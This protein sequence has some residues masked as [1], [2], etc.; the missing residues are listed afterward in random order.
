MPRG[1]GGRHPD[2]A[3]LS[4]QVTVGMVRVRRFT[5]W[6]ANGRSPGRWTLLEESC[7]PSTKARGSVTQTLTRTM[8]SIDLSA[9]GPESAAQ[10]G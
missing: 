9:G 6:T 10:P 8:L 1:G 3:T 5:N 4:P 7:R 2:G